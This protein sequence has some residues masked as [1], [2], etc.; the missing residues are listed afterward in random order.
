MTKVR[1]E[2]L[3]GCKAVH[4]HNPTLAV[5]LPKK[6]DFSKATL[7]AFALFTVAAVA[8]DLANG[9][10]VTESLI[11]ESMSSIESSMEPKAEEVAQ[12]MEAEI[13][14]ICAKNPDVQMINIV[15]HSHGGWSTARWVT[16]GHSAALAEN[17]G[18]SF[19]I[20]VMGTPV[21]VPAGT[22]G[23]NKVVQLHNVLD[24]ASCRFATEEEKNQAHVV[25]ASENAYHA[26]SKY[27]TWFESVFQTL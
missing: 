18:V 5:K 13:T 15:G 2:K 4:L 11:D 7:S 8:V 24:P 21:V 12:M 17:L 9:G 10:T 23:V 3:F 25:W 14:R 20:Y 16:N 19:D 27:L 6:S 1:L 26:S 22:P